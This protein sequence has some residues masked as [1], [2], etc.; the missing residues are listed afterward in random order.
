M[1][2]VISAPPAV[3]AAAMIETAAWAIA[4]LSS[5]PVS[6]DAS[7]LEPGGEA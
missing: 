2:R 7:A 1:C 6:D 5:R 4:G 3:N